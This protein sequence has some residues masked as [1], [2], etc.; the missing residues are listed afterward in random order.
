MPQPSAPAIPNPGMP[1]LPQKRPLSGDGTFQPPVMSAKRPNLNSPLQN[2]SPSMSPIPQH[3][4]IRSPIPSTARASWEDRAIIVPSKDLK[5]KALEY[6][7]SDQE[8]MIDRVLCG[9]AKQ[10]REQKAKPDSCLVLTLMYLAKIRPLFF[11]SNTVVEAFSSLL[12][13]DSLTHFAKMKNNLVPVLVVN[14]FHRAFHDESPWPEIF[15][16]LYVEDSLG[17]R[18]W[19]DNEEC[20]VRNSI[21]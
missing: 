9:A 2:V 20:K 7:E 6:E 11:C 14:L 13:R 17:D 4:V 10:L 12:K 16:K 19:V 8:E 21:L 1:K 15:I 3:S 5:D 18:V